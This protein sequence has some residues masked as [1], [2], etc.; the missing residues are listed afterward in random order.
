MV[1]VYRKRTLPEDISEPSIDSGYAKVEQHT[2]ELRP[3]ACLAKSR[4]LSCQFAEIH[5]V[6]LKML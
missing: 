5:P 6:L 3:V 2:V 4:N 1:F